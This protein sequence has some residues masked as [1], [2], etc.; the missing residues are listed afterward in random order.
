MVSIFVI[1]V[2]G[3]GGPAPFQ[4]SENVGISAPE[5]L[6][7]QSILTEQITSSLLTTFLKLSGA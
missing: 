1:S 7:L 2:V 6:F 5:V 4:T 3:N